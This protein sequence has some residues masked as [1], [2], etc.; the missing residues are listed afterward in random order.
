M[1]CR[2]PPRPK[3]ARCDVIRTDVTV[4]NADGSKTETVTDTNQGR[5]HA[6][7]IRRSSTTNA[8]G[9][10]ITIDRDTTG[11]GYNNQ[12]ETIATAVN[13]STADTVSNYAQM[14]R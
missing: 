2:L 7:A 6:C 5:W 12:I 13:G 3:T 4:L 9:T 8:T 14:A 1:A 10:S 11:L